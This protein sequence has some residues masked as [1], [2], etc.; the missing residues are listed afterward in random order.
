MQNSPFTLRTRQIRLEA[1]DVVSL[2]LEALDG[3]A[4]P[5]YAPGAH[6]DVQVP[7]GPLRSYSLIDPPS[8]SIRW[9][10]AVKREP[11]SRGGS[12]W[13]HEQSRVGMPLSVTFAGNHFALEEAAPLSVFVAGGIGITPL[14][15]MI[16]RLVQLGRPWELHYAAASPAAMPFQAQLAGYAAR[17][18]GRV[19]KYFTDAGNGRMDIAGVLAATADD[20]HVYCCGPAGMIDDF[21]LA[22]AGRTPDNVHH[23]RFAASQAAVTDGGFSLQLARDGRL[24]EVPAGKTILDVLLAAGVDVP[25]ACTQGVGGA[26]RVTVLEGEPEHRDD[27]LSDAERAAN[28]SILVCCSGARTASLTLDV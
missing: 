16:G 27:F 19:V 18:Q 15:S 6:V 20:A 22:A 10:I 14:L 12:R 11:G 13:F 21:L 28:D 4:L 3:A 24:L 17:G 2:E 9:R 1:I 26:C 5:A 8:E 23:E 7:G 25:Y